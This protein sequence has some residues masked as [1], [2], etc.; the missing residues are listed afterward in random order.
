MTRNQDE[1]ID[2]Y[3]KRG[4]LWIHD[5]NPKRPH[6]LLT[7]GQHSNG[8]FNSRLVITDEGLLREAA[9]DLIELYSERGGDIHAVNGVVGPQTGATKLAELMSRQIQARNKVAC[10]YVSPSK[11]EQNGV[12]SMVFSNEELLFLP[13][14]LV[15]ACDDVVTTTLS[16]GLAS[17][18]VTE[19][20]GIL[21]NFI[22]ALVNRSGAT[23][24][25]G[26]EIVALIEHH[27]P[28]WAREECPLCEVGSEAIRPKDGDG[29]NWA[30]LNADY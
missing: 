23:E 16:V 13:D 8:F 6:A 9:H 28:I 24:T 27:M 17:E 7:S 2:E 1:W 30:L 29:A 11:K 10:F 4:A 20:G 22:L 14:Q 18:A 25:G 15:L 21:L 12:K 26:K 3:V 19:A 5:G